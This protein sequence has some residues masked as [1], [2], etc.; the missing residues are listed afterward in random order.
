MLA[1]AGPAQLSY[2]GGARTK[3]M[4]NSSILLGKNKVEAAEE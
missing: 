1:C 2:D 4:W 3:H